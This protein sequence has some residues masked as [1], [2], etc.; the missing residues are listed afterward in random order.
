MIK[1]SIFDEIK[2]EEFRKIHKLQPYR[3]KQIYLEIFKNSIVDFNEM[4]TLSKELRETLNEC[5][6][7]LPFKIWK[8]LEWLD[9]TKISLLTNDWKTIETVIMHHFDKYSENTK[10]LDWT[11]ETDKQINRL[12]LCV[13]TQIWCAVW[14]IFCVTWKLWFSRNLSYEEIIW[15]LLIANNYI[16]NKYWKKEDNNWNKIR[17]VVFMGM[18]EPL[19]N[20]DELIKSINTMLRQDRFSLSKK[21]ITISSSGIIPWIQ[22]LIDENIPVMLAISLHS[23]DQIKRMEL[24]PI[25]QKYKL[26]DLMKLIEQYIKKSWNRLFYEYIMIKD[27]TDSPETAKQ[28]WN[29][30]KKQLC[31]VNLIAYNENPAMPDLKET[32]SKSIEL[33]KQILEDMWITV[34][35][36]NSLGRDL[37]GACGQLWYENL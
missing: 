3:I 33:F 8:I 31:H 36:R 12:S 1:N 32:P 20:Y 11:S 7:I 35:I 2:L 37:K 22:R 26:N 23:P 14:C 29:L 17:N 4:T 9:T 27:I 10:N 30:I 24:M 16:K 19:L 25:S 5:F 28:L 34:T 13:S 21:H 6:Y 15:Q 18:G